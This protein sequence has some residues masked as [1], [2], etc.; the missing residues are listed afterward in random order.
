M[1]VE[2]VDSPAVFGSGGLDKELL[3]VGRV[4]SGIVGSFVGNLIHGL[5]ISFL[6][7]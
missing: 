2:G 7:E 4:G 3:L 6:R 1:E 5:I